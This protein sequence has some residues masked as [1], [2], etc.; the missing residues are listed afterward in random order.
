MQ[1]EI[2][3]PIAHCVSLDLFLLIV[4]QMFPKCP[5]PNNV[6]AFRYSGFMVRGLRLL[7]TFTR[8]THILLY[9]ATANPTT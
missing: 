9:D 4:G 6:S 5:P 1:Q 8:E 2:Y 7:T 3:K